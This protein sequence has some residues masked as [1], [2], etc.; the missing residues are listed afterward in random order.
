MSKILSALLSGGANGDLRR[1]GR[2]VRRIDALE[3]EMHARSDAELRSLSDSLRE[4]V[5]AG[6]DIA[7][8]TDESFALVREAGRRVTG[9]R[10]YD[11]QLVGGLALA[12]GR[13]AESPTGSG[14]AIPT[15]SYLPTPTGWRHASDIQVG[16]ELFG[17]DGRPTKVV[18][19]FPQGELEAFRL[20]FADGR[21]QLAAGNH[22]WGVAPTGPEEEPALTVMTTD[23]LVASDAQWSVPLAEPARYKTAELPLPPYVLGVMLGGATIGRSEVVIEARNGVARGVQIKLSLAL[24]IDV[25][26]RKVGRRLW[27]VGASEGGSDVCRLLR[28]LFGGMLVGDSRD[29]YIPNEYLVADA[30]QRSD[31]M[32][33][34]TDMLAEGRGGRVVMSLPS[35]QLRDDVRQLAWSLGMVCPCVHR[36]HASNVLELGADRQGALRDHTLPAY[37]GNSFMLPIVSIEDTGRRQ[38]MVC[39]AVD[40]DDHLFQCG[41]YIVT[42]NTIMAAAPSYVRALAGRGAHVVTVNDY[43]ARRDAEDIGRIHHFLG[44]S[45]G[46]LQN[47]MD[48]AGRHEAYASDI[49]YGT[50]SEFGFDYLR[51][52]MASS[53]AG[54]VQRGHYFAIVDE[55]DSILIDEARTPLII[56]G[57][58]SGETRLY[59][60][61]ARAVRGLKADEDYDLNKAN[62]TIAATDKGLRTIEGRLG[63]SI[64]DDPSGRLVNHLQ[65][66]LK[67]EYMFH[68]DQQYAVIGGEVKIVDEFTGRIMG[69]RRYSNGLHQAIEAKEG[70]RVQA[71]SMT[72]ATT[73]L[74]NYFRSY[75][76]LSGM[77]GTALSEAS[78]FREIYH[79]PVTVVPPNVPSRRV[80]HPDVIYVDED[81]KYKAVVE[82][83]VAR[84]AKGQPCLVGTVTIEH[85][86][87]LSRML[88][89]RGVRHSVLNAKHHEQEAAII[90]QAGRLGAVTI[91]TNMAGRGTDIL[92]G[93]NPEG[94][95]HDSLV[96]QGYFGRDD[97]GSVV[98]PSE[99]LARETLER[100]RQQCAAERERVIAAGG[101]CVIGTERHEARRID[102]Q[103]RGRA[104][105][106][107]DPG[108]TVFYVSLE[109]DI[110]RCFG[111][112]ADLTASYLKMADDPSVP[113]TGRAVSKVIE[114]AQRHIED[115]N[116]AVRRDVVKYDDVMNGQRNA[117]YGLRQR[118]LTATDDSMRDITRESVEMAVD[119]AVR[120]LPDPAAL[121]RWVDELSAD[122][123]HIAD[124]D[125]K[126][127]VQA[128]VDAKVAEVGP[129]S[130]L[131]LQRTCLLRVIDAQW[132]SYISE[133]E[134][135]K[136]GIGMRSIGQRD[137]LVEWRRDAYACFD[138]LMG[139]VRASYL[140]TLLHVR[141]T[142]LDA[143]PPRLNRRQRR[144]AQHMAK[145]RRV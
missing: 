139:D 66:A 140:R 78:E 19:V 98:L 143:Q 11:V 44:L 14:K 100:F 59:R 88:D 10:L 34:I 134:A 84:H 109:D 125:P 72:Y 2:A 141:V 130:E 53:V 69:D 22:R 102:N 127:T 118:V 91:A 93:G 67:A 75:E 5:A 33:G 37:A 65:Q 42:H 18:G 49:T 81:A 97:D 122:E 41:D 40:A 76:H 39:F 27:S 32:S 133:M 145:A 120:A 13:I 101:L 15:S 26:V 117:V 94:L 129:A 31:L 82:D 6:A 104:G 116:Y 113:L 87:R 60:D 28:G 38:E 47:G 137:P 126:A 83:V 142:R 105:R 96:A 92:L 62:D 123:L 70:V 55:A 50:N 131:D 89:K 24:G 25:S 80:D 132:V 107:G 58:G 77:T 16:D 36:G 21:T 135:L 8:V 85:S 35:S 56:A 4:R 51:D 136:N 1:Y 138:R 108:E 144:A 103:L 7:D 61:F 30:R 43:L 111:K 121:D 48:A 99:D 106:Q 64:Y 46:L 12:D 86:E 54:Q 63:L 114:N 115:S 23:E 79:T 110:M 119:R 45:V 71:E 112:G 73:T 95:A 9:K 74:Q 3:P 90:A 52:N 57:E 20:T 128:A 124:D 68:R 29:F 17:R